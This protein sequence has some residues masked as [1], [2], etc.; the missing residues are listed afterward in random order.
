MLRAPGGKGGTDSSPVIRSRTNKKP[1]EAEKSNEIE[2]PFKWH[3]CIPYS[4]RK[5]PYSIREV[6][7]SKRKSLIL[8]ENPL[9]SRLAIGTF[10]HPQSIQVIKLM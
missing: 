6:P 3:V 4:I 2:N 7:Y 5:I 9:F 8:K 10:G 1:N